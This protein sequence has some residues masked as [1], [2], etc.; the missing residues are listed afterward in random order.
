MAEY[1]FVTF[2]HIEA[3]LREVYDVVLESLRWP[4]WWQGVESVDESDPGDANGI[5]SVRRYTWKSRLSYKLSFAACATR[6]EPLAALEAN[7]SGDLEGTGRW[8]FS[9]DQGVT[10]VCYEWHVRTTKQWMNLLA[11]IARARFEQNHHALMQNG[12]EGLARLLGARLVNVSHNALPSTSCDARRPRQM[13]I[14]AAIGAGI[15]AGIIATAVQLALWWV[16]AIPLP[17]ILLRDARLAAA[18]VMG[19]T[20]LPPPA[21]FEWGVMLTATV[22]HFALSICYGV[23]LA[24]VLSRLSLRQALPVGAVFGL[25]LYGT[26]MYGFTALF[27]WFKASRDWITALA[28]MSFGIATATIYSIWQSNQWR[29]DDV[30]SNADQVG[31]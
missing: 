31:S 18:I 10:T 6:I 8:L 1:R 28:H 12:A 29:V 27:P 21:T 14:V 2:W 19:I 15:G 24:P 4:D 22:V 7:V 9:H 26:N 17:D 25:L 23:I 3:S 11:P 30:R 5:G 20:V 16:F 13:N